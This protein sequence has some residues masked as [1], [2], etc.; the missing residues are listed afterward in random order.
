MYLDVRVLRAVEFIRG[1]S[2]PLLDENALRD[3]YRIGVAEQFADLLLDW[4]DLI[5]AGALP[6]GHPRSPVLIEDVERHGG[7]P[8][9]RVQGVVSDISGRH[10]QYRYPGGGGYLFFQAVKVCIDRCGFPSGV[11]EN[12]VVDLGEN[13]LG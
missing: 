2:Y 8:V 7:E 12:R 11:G 3:A 6:P 1:D 5:F 4:L 9:I 13:A 10:A